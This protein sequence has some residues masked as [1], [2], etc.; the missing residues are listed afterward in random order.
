MVQILL[1]SEANLH[2]PVI[3]LSVL[4]R[5]LR[6]L[7]VIE[8]VKKHF[9]IPVSVDTFKSSVAESSIQAGADLVND[10]WGLKYDPKM[11]A[12]IAKYDVACC[13]MTQQI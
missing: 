11:A 5:A 8:A 1:I 7:P 3:L 6:V 2:V 13:L 10:I 12:V 9:D 4:T